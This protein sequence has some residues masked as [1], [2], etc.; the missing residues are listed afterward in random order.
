V[1]RD[2]MPS[3]GLSTYMYDAAELRPALTLETSFEDFILDRNTEGGPHAGQVWPTA[4][5]MMDEIV[6]MLPKEYAACEPSFS[7]AKRQLQ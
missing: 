2:R 7:A 4:V 5:P 1:R 3:S 6:L